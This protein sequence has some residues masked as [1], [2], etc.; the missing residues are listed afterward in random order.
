MLSELK[1][2]LSYKEDN[3]QKSVFTTVRWN[4]IVLAGDVGSGYADVVIGAF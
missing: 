2:Y 4:P 3:K 1:L